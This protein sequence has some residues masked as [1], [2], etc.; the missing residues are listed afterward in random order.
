M[1][2]RSDAELLA[3]LRG[4]DRSAYEV[5]W[6]RHSDAAHRHARRLFPSRAEDLVAE[7]FLAIYQ[8]VTTTDAGPQFAFRSYLK[9]V[10]RNTAKRWQR[11]SDLLVSSGFG[12]EGDGAFSDHED[13]IDRRD[14]LSI[15]ERDALSADVA[16]SF[17]ELPERW[18]R[19]LWLAEV[20]E[21]DRSEI[22]RELG[23][24]PNAVSALQRRARTGLKLQW[25]T[26]QIPPALRE[27]R[28]HVAR[29]IPQY[30]TEPRNHAVAAEVTAHIAECAECDELL[31]GMRGAGERL[32]GKTLAVLLGAAGAGVPTALWAGTGTTAAAAVLATT[33]AAGL[34]G[35]A[36]IVG[37]GALTV[38]MLFATFTVMQPPSVAD[39]GPGRA[40]IVAPAEPTTEPEAPSTPPT[41][42][43][44]V[45]P[46][47]PVTDPP[48]GRHIDDP[49]I[50]NVDLSTD[51]DSQPDPPN[52]PRPRPVDPDTNTPTGPET[53]DLTPGMT[54]PT[55]STGY[56]AP[57]LA[58]R[59]AP[60]TRILVDVDLS[61]PGS[62]A[63]PEWRRYDAAV[64]D[65]GS[66]TFDMRTLTNTPG[67]HEYRVQAS[68]GTQLSAP[69][70]GTFT[71]ESVV[72]QGFEGIT[73]DLTV[74]EAGSTG[75]VI[76]VRGPANG[77]VFASTIE[78]HMATIVLD[79][80]GYAR[81][82][83]LMASNGWYYFTFRVRDS[84]GFLGAPTE[85]GVVV[86]D[87]D[88]IFDPW[89]PGPED[90]TF[91]IT[92]P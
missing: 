24:K 10:L 27:D 8:Q 85:G 67:T 64:A 91:T 39:A 52:K 37:A 29:L 14:S 90:M 45:P 26:R 41:P 70:S 3:A 57:V 51:P 38:G 58:G 82:R 81:K 54:T 46:V 68:D 50:P 59:T 61:R 40:R 56:L 65:D 73:E 18:Q 35:W 7:A 66:W 47:P 15:I 80:N 86:Y 9:A 32:Q 53:D 4:G 92:D 21:A 11:E 17:L 28:A 42:P 83:I 78:G 69:T 43:T 19:V 75:V 88:V 23:I 33:T 30:L 31:R 89:G 48:T 1:D 77:E 36:L 22:A 63:P 60:G 44:T 76:T 5:L 49:T 20:A 6:R 62:G 71:V 16:A 13:L 84:E 34:S 79:G 87:P 55:T 2:V 74:E 72:V 12:T 25:L